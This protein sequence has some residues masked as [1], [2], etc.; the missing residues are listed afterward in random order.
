MT[1]TFPRYGQCRGN[2]SFHKELEKHPDW[3]YRNQMKPSDT[4]LHDHAR[5]EEEQEFPVSPVQQRS[6][7]DELTD[8]WMPLSYQ[9]SKSYQRDDD[10][11]GKLAMGYR[12]ISTAVQS[13]CWVRWAPDSS[14]LQPWGAH[15]CSEAQQTHRDGQGQRCNK[16]AVHGVTEQMEIKRGHRNICI[17]VSKR[18][19]Q[20]RRRRNKRWL[21]EIKKKLIPCARE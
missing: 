2:Q 8:L 11:H 9:Y 10:D 14:H 17:R 12:S 21:I 3:H 13:R 1:Q 20:W 19:Q 15:V 16:T 6:S 4:A 7:A 5:G 18:T